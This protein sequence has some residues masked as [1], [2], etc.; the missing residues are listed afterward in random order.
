GH[1]EE[2]RSGQTDG[3]ERVAG[4]GDRVQVEQAHHARVVDTATPPRPAHVA[5]DPPRRTRR[6]GRGGLYALGDRPP[7]SGGDSGDLDEVAEHGHAHILPHRTS[8]RIP[9]GGQCWR[10]RVT[11]RGCRPRASGG[12]ASLP[13]VTGTA[14]AASKTPPAKLD[15]ACAAAIDLARDA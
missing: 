15:P 14:T 2:D 4:A 9:M 1:V 6:A 3:D 13:A 5:A 8:R 7:A 10:G 11:R 12:T